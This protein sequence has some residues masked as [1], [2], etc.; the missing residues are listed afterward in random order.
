MVNR[1]KVVAAV[2]DLLFRVK[3]EEAAKRAGLEIV[4]APSQEEVLRQAKTQPAV[5]ILDLNDARTE[6]LQTIEKL[7][8]D[9]ETRS[10]PLLGYVS[11]VQAELIKAAQA[12]GCD[13]VVARSAFAQ[14]LSKLLSRFI[15]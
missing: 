1:K 6:P 7:K 5:I 13:T 11:H 12:Q 15:N 2:N 8:S 9:E 10:V 4:S 14:D 3:I